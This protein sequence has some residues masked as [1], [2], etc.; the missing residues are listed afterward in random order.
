MKHLIISLI[1]A[2]STTSTFAIDSHE[3]HINE[4][5]RAVNKVQS[6]IAKIGPSFTVKDA[7]YVH[8]NSITELSKPRQE[9]YNEVFYTGLS[10]L[11][12]PPKLA[13]HEMIDRCVAI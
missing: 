10:L 11:G 13:K 8:D 1:A 12:K 6:L 3:Q 5:I 4:C 2:L 7:V 9:L